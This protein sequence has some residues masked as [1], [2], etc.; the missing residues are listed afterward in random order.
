MTIHVA[1]SHVTDYQFDRT[2][3]LGPHVVRLRPAPHT[4]TPIESYSLRV[5]PED[6]FLNWQQ[7]PFGNFEARL[8]FPE[9][10]RRLTV[11]VD[12]VADLAAINPFDFFLEDDAEEI[13]FTYEPSLAADLAPYLVSPEPGPLLRSWL[14]RIDRTPKRTVEQLV[15][16]NSAL[17]DD[18]E[19][20]VR[21][22]PGVQTPEQTL[23]RAFGSCRDSAW[24]LVH[25]LRAEGMAAR[26]VSGYLVQLTADQAP[27]DGPAGPTEDFTDLHAWAEVFLP[28]AGWVG[29]DPTSG[30]F[31][32]E[33]HIP[34]AATPSPATAAPISGLV[35]E[36]E[37][38][39][40][41]LNSVT[42]IH[43]DPRVTLPYD[44]EQR[45]AIDRLGK[46]VDRRLDEADVRLTMGG[47]PTFVSVSDM[48]SPEWNTLADGP[49]KR[50]KA[51]SLMERLRRRFGT[52][53]LVHHGQGKWYP[54][55][56]L[57]RWQQALI[58]RTDGRA[59]W[60]ADE[61]LAD[62]T[63]APSAHGTG[64]DVGEAFVHGL[65]GNLGLD[66][67]TVSPA[68]EDP[69]HQL[70]QEALL[71]AGPPPDEDLDPEDPDYLTEAGR[72]ALVGAIDRRRGRPTGWVLPL[73][74]SWPGDGWASRGWTTRRNH[75]YLLPGDSPLGFRLPISSLA[76]T[77]PP[78]MFEPSPFARLRPL[79]THP[80]VG[81]LAL[82][83]G[84]TAAEAGGTGEAV[85]VA[86]GG[87]PTALC[88]EVRNGHLHVFLPPLPDAEAAV[89]LVAAIEATADD[90]ELP[91]V[92]EGYQ[93]PGDSRLRSLVVAPDPGV[94]EVNVPPS[95]DWSELSTTIDGVYDDAR[96]VGLSTE[97]FDLDGTHTGTGG[98]NHV[99]IGGA[100]PA[101]SPLLRRPSLLRSLLTYWQHHPALSYVFSGRFIGPSSQAPRVDE[102]RDDRIYELETAFA[103]LDRLGPDDPPWL[104]DRIL[105]HLLVDQTGNTHRAEFCIDKLF[106]PE[107]ERGRL[108][109]LELRAFEMPPHPDMA[110][111]QALL[112]R[113][114]VARCWDD[115][116]HHDPVR[117]GTALH[118]RYLLPWYLERDLQE[119]TAD[120]ADHGIDL[121]RAWFDPFL[122][123]RFPRHGTASVGGLN[124]ELR[125][126]IEPWHVLGEE[127]TGSGM[128]RYVDSSV[129]RLQLTVEGH[130]DGRHV[131]TCNGV[132]VPLHATDVPETSVAG[133]RFKA[134][135]P[136]SGLHP[137]LGIDSPLTFDVYD[138]WTG[139]AVG[140][141]R[142]HVVHPGGLA[143][144]APPVNAAVAESRRRTRFE[145]AGHTPSA[146]VPV[147]L[148]PVD[149]REFPHTLDLRRATISGT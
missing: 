80:P 146:P 104:V 54:G 88:V 97:K 145:A 69:L 3:G 96:H 144:E 77:P 93:L 121:D 32:A 134:W 110:L 36:C 2:V 99:T 5:E 68:W 94:L 30:L 42:R 84:G 107:G 63:A 9:R 129:E 72:R 82:T 78:P 47:E 35:D 66:G 16:I 140:G 106:S 28:G 113:S 62:P 58:W 74:R 19:Y 23:R 91:V 92:V 13:P 122:E 20:T 111:V 119:V 98:G 125:G 101:D 149:H 147:D 10:A 49:D 86:G 81:P 148:R 18:I 53:G 51:R 118:D 61:L 15:A 131:V 14:H 105:R 138:T 127:A 60:R 44:A 123:F 116:Y 17:A 87:P 48:A 7:D 46:L 117:W 108:G 70:W 95:A 4:R 83:G 55:E 56:P 1:L 102:S 109:L 85:T 40:S 114:L 37:V 12:L 132:R 45:A 137:T 26:F 124:L 142:Y 143:F 59:L 65:A 24:L 27:I 139:R 89:E 38:E 11:T 71:P 126:A 128:A 112:V 73:F 21:M 6:H 75:L 31:A 50:L 33:G 41:F 135:Q 130:I 22:E 67:S 136:P 34:L 120:L 8:V 43:E 103:E 141:C 90:L 133:I 79:P 57:P 25:I 100:T 115:P 64:P 76:W 39:F 52:G 29:L